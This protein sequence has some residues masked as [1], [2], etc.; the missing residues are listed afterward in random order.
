MQIL[1]IN[2]SKRYFNAE[3]LPLLLPHDFLKKMFAS[4]EPL[5]SN[6]T[7]LVVIDWLLSTSS[8]KNP[9]VHSSYELYKVL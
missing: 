6:H 5:T 4:Y 3:N 2:F 7:D 8:F 9:K 1:K